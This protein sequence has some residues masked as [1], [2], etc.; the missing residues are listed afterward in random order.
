MKK[1]WVRSGHITT[2]LGRMTLDN[3][4]FEEEEGLDEIQ[5]HLAQ[6]FIRDEFGSE[7]D[8]QYLDKYD[9]EKGWYMTVCFELM[10]EDEV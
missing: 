8:R 2:D 3:K 7:Y 9:P 1:V 5:R 10:E 4:I 6:G